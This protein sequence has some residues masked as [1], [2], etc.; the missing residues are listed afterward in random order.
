MRSSL[1][2]FVTVT[3]VTMLVSGCNSPE[4]I[5]ANRDACLDRA[6]KA[7]A[8]VMERENVTHLPGDIID[9]RAMTRVMAADANR[10]SARLGCKNVYDACN[11]SPYG[12]S[13]NLPF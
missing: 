12:V 6:E 8:A 13:C 10:T 2:D 11:S 9:P 5:E 4:Q 1:R 7:Y 3:I